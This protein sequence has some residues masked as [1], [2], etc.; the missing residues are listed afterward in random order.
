[1][2]VK[3]SIVG[4]ALAGLK[5][6]AKGVSAGR[7]LPDGS[8]EKV[9]EIPAVRIFSEVPFAHIGTI[10]GTGVNVI[11]SPCVVRLED[12]GTPRKGK[13]AQAGKKASSSVNAAAKTGGGTKRTVRSAPAKKTRNKTG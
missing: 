5:A 9:V 8:S 2:A 13:A 12:G 4:K 10:G 11:S 1:M 6:A 3:K 7:G